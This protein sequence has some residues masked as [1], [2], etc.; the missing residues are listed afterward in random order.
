MRRFKKRNFKR[1]VTFRKKS[2]KRFAK[3]V[4]KAVCYK[5]EKKYVDFGFENA[6]GN[7]GI[8]VNLTEIITNGSQIQNRIG[9]KIKLRYLKIKFSLDSAN[10]DLFFGRFAILRGRTAGLTGADVPTGDGAYIQFFDI[11]KFEIVWERTFNL[12]DT[13]IN[14]RNK[15]FFNKT[16]RIFKEIMFNTGVVAPAVLSPVTNPYF[17]YY[18]TN[19]VVLTTNN[20]RGVVRMYFNDI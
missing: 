14:G 20:V 4:N 9:N 18:W 1:R 2:F 11:E 3:R 6:I 19:D 8:L 13:D 5:A 15:T 10:E 16:L 12:G 17:L 7:S